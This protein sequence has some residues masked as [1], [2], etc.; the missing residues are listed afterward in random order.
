MTERPTAAAEFAL[1]LYLV[2]HTFI[3]DSR[4]F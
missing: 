3:L 4:R 2:V 1:L